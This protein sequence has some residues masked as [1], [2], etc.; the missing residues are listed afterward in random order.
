M[1]HVGGG[2][3]ASLSVKALIQCRGGLAKETLNP[4]RELPD[5][6]TSTCHLAQWKTNSKTRERLDSWVQMIENARMLID[7]RDAIRGLR[8]G[9][10]TTLLAFAILTLTLAAG[11]ITFSVVDA[12]ALRRMPFPEPGR[13]AAIAIQERGSPRL[14][15]SAPQDFFTW[16]AQ[17]PAF[18]GVAATSPG[19]LQYAEGGATEQLIV[20]RITA[21][22]FDVLRVR[23]ALGTTFSAVHEQAG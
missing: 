10:G 1:G 19:G 2:A 3:S 18:E 5:A 14:G 6:P 23:P 22:L 20:L 17:T 4:V 21:N 15:T 12:I 7:L 11:T 16:R 13:L 8:A 9:K